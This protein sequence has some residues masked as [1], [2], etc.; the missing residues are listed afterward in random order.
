MEAM[1]NKSMQPRCKGCGRTPEQ[2][3]EYVY[4]AVTEKKYFKGANDVVRQDDGTYNPETGQFYC[5]DCYIKA[6]M[7]LGTA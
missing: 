4:R 7:P 6:G 3:D 5:T 2:I 1:T